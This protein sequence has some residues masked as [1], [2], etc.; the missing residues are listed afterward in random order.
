VRPKPE[1]PGGPVGGAKPDKEH[2]VMFAFT[3]AGEGELRD[4]SKPIGYDSNGNTLFAPRG[5]YAKL[6]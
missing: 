6:W 3:G 2:A 1:I 5:F 4:V